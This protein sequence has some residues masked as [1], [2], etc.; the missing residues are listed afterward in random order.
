MRA[1][2]GARAVQESSFARQQH[3]HDDSDEQF[4]TLHQELKPI[5]SAKTG[6]SSSLTYVTTIVPCING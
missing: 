5:Y 6:I 1:F 2:I 3:N 4:D